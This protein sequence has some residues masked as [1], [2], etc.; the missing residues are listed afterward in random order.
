MVPALAVRLDSEH[1]RKLAELAA[2]KG[3]PVSQVVRHMID[4][5]YEEALQARRLRAAH[6]LAL[7]TVEDAP[8]PATLSR[9]LQGAYEP[10]GLS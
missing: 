1:R 7:M 4:N 3:A 2:E 6:E 5:A 9:Q 8:D 10:S